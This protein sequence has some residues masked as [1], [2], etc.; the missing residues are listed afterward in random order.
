MVVAWG[1]EYKLSLYKAAQTMAPAKVCTRGSDAA[2]CGVDHV[3]NAHK[4]IRTSVPV[5]LPALLVPPR[6]CGESSFPL[7]SLELFPSR[8]TPIHA[9]RPPPADSILTLSL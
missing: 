9:G 6:L 7:G 8:S 2:K 1:T 3:V 4:Q 5:V